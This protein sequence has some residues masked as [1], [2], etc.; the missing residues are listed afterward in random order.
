MTVLKVHG[1]IGGL[2]KIIAISELVQAI[3]GISDLIN[4]RL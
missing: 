1:E 3:E 4:L 2:L